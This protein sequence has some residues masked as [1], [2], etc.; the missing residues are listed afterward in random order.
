MVFFWALCTLNPLRHEAQT[1]TRLTVEPSWMRT[2]W[3]FGF[4]RRRVALNEWLRAFP[5]VGLCPNE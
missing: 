4:H 2:F 1:Q 3:R 5:K